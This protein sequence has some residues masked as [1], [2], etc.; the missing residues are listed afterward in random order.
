MSILSM[1]PDALARL[2]AAAPAPALAATPNF[3]RL[4]PAPPPPPV[5]VRP[6]APPDITGIGA[7]VLAKVPVPPP[8]VPPVPPG[9]DDARPTARYQEAPGAEVRVAVLG[10]RTF[11]DWGRFCRELGACIEAMCQER[12]SRNVVLVCG[13]SE[14]PD[15]MVR[16]YAAERRMRVVE[17]RANFEAHGKGAVYVRNRQVIHAA[18][19]LVAFWDGQSKG[20]GDAIS[21]AAQ[22][23]IPVHAVDADPPVLPGQPVQLPQ[24]TASDLTRILN[25]PVTDGT[26]VPDMTPRFVRPGVRMEDLQPGPLKPVQ[27][28]ALY[29]AQAAGGL[30]GAIGVGGGKTLLSFLLPVAIGSKVAVLFVPPHLYRKTLRDFA[31]LRLFWTLP[32]LGDY[33]APGGL[34]LEPGTPVL[35]IV[36]MGQLSTA[37][38]SN[39]MDR[40]E[41]D[42]VLVDE[43]HYLRG[44]KSA[45]SKRFARYFSQKPKTRACL[46]SG[47]I[48]NSSLTDYWH[49]CR[50]ALKDGSPLPLSAHTAETFDAV[51]GTRTDAE[52]AAEA[53]VRGRE[54]AANAYLA[55]IRRRYCAWA[56]TDDPGEAFKKRLVSTP[57]WVATSQVDCDAGLTIVER[58][59]AV[60]PEVTQAISM[61]NGMWQTPDGDEFESGLELDQ[62]L[63][64]LNAGF[65]NVWVWP[66]G[67]PDEEWL[68]ARRQWSRAVRTVLQRN[69]QHMDSPLLVER[70][71]VKDDPRL[72][73]MMVELDAEERQSVLALW[74]QWRKVKGRP[75]PETKPV[76]I[77]RFLVQEAVKRA[78]VIMK[79]GDM[80]VL[81]YENPAVGD[82][83][84]E[85]TGWRR[86]GAGDAD[87]RAL[88]DLAQRALDGTAP[89]EPV[90]CSILC[91]GTGKNLQAW[92]H[93]LV[94]QTPGRGDTVEQLLGRLHRQGQRADEVVFEWM[95]HTEWARKCWAKART[96]ADYQQRTQGQPQRLLLATIEDAEDYGDGD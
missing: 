65:Y 28:A 45:R 19:A 57:G 8:G 1:G 13:G 89:L 95:L 24:K 93:A 2:P 59:C 35:Y 34:E 42:L 80:P 17:Y 74:H 29:W 36:S 90:I 47:T 32:V 60:P 27:S 33:R 94:V 87:S 54:M 12:G 7:G 66:N 43:A 3:L 26:G 20:T 92:R 71:C 69:I 85:A 14:G 96:E 39:L 48:T 68:H 4:V 21:Y 51:F 73:A 49:L 86:F 15:Q 55:D 83:L 50:W 91:H 79:R 11:K 61:A 10:T 62:A 63:S 78:N 44:T 58:G 76:W 46:L 22:R 41:P 53:A 82:A 56:G 5:D 64:T 72:G 18:H 75:S 37:A 6:A 25:L 81:W 16:R 67:D 52:R 40:L 70:A 84:A 77:S 38:N 9:F 23:G 88:T 30:V 31:R